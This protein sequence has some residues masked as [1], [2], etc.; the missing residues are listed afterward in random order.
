[1]TPEDRLATALEDCAQ[2]GIDHAFHILDRDQHLAQDIEDGRALRMLREA[3]PGWW[4]TVTSTYGRGFKVL[5][6]PP[7]G[8]PSPAR[9]PSGGG[10]TIAAAAD[11]CREAL[12]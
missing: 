10:P 1:V 6:E 2:P 4:I 7:L 3:L 5:C 12:S 9:Y 11:A 8:V